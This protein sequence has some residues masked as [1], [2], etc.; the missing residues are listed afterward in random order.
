MDASHDGKTDAGELKTLAELGITQINVRDTTASHEVRDGNRVLAQGTF[1]INGN[2]QE[3]LAVDFLGDPVSST[4]LAQASGT[5]V[6]STSEGS[7]TTAYASHSLT[8]ETL[9]AAQLGVNN[10]YGS[11]GDDTL[12]AAPT[13]SWLVGGG[14]SNVYNGAAG[15]DVFVISASDVM[16]NI[17]GNGG[18]DMA[19]IVG[20]EGVA[21][22]M[23]RAGLT[24]AQGGRR[25][26][27]Y[28]A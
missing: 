13:G 12:I 26:R 9:N 3:A 1:T 4:L 16:E 27:Y 11:A 25:H 20:D 15:D 6:I 22:N 19:I 28:S 8:G 7:T 5:Q 23:A 21:L 14:G 24:V 18:R 17:H 2:L 10:L